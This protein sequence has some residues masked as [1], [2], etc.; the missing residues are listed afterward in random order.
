MNEDFILFQTAKLAKE[1][2][3]NI[4]TTKCYDPLSQDP[5]HLFDYHQE[6]LLSSKERIERLIFAPT[7]SQLQKWLR[8]QKVIVL[9]GYHYEF[10]STPYTYW[11]YREF[12][13]TPLNEWVHD[14]KSYEEALEEGL[15]E[16]LKILN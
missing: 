9:P 12:E 3:F 8:D 11:I 15:K 2:G 13:S 5:N 14:F 7:Q 4:P 1:K 6:C 16:G 10:D